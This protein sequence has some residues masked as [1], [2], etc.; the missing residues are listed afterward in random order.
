MPAK[1]STSTTPK[2]VKKSSSVQE[3]YYG[4][5]KRKTAVA[6]VRLYKNGKGDLTVNDQEG[7]KYFSLTKLIAVLNAPLRLTSLTKKF[8]ITVKVDGGGVVSQAEAIRHAIARALLKYD[9]ALRITLKKAG[10]LTRD[11]R[12]KER[13]KPGLKKARRAPQFSKR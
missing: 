13:K 3:Y 4:T 1:A 10:F 11:A 9:E 7:A 2:T 8:D 5:G 6:R 12:K